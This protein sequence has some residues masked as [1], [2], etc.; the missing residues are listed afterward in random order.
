MQRRFSSLTIVVLFVALAGFLIIATQ[1]VNAG[2]GKGKNERGRQLY[3][4]YCASCHGEDAKGNGPA[5]PALKTAPANLT[6]IPK[7]NGKF[8]ALKVSRVISGD[9]FVLGHGSREMP[10]WGEVFKR[11]RDSAMAKSNVYA[12]MRY[13]ESIQ[14]K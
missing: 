10:I 13:V 14:A 7:E 3:M 1:D 8:P 2:Q 4:T 9:D 12:L 6:A 5:A 11:Q